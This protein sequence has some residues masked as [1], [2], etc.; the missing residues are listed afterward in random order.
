[1]KTKPSFQGKIPLRQII[2]LTVKKQQAATKMN[3]S[4]TNGKSLQIQN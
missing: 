3:L 4:L 1:M 2:R